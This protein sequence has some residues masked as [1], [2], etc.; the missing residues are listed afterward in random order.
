R[1]RARPMPAC[2]TPIPRP[3]SPSSGGSRAS[4]SRRSAGSADPPVSQAGPALGDSEFRDLMDRLGPFEPAP[5]LAVAVSGGADSM[6]L[7]LLAD[8]WARRRRGK[9]VA[10][11]VDHGL[12]P[13]ARA[14]ARAAHRRLAALGIEAHLLVWGGAKPKTGI[15]AAAREARYRLMAGWCRRHGVLHLLLGHHREDQAE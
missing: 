3:R 12:R 5:V 8:R 13:G 15:Q 6:A 11:T 9:I 7:A 10:L 14:E 1:R 2:S 4:A